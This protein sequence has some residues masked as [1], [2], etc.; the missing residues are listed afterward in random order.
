MEER[1]MEPRVGELNPG[2]TC[3]REEA[4]IMRSHGSP[5]P[6]RGLIK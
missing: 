2:G 3:G 6:R 5:P 1:I 4:V